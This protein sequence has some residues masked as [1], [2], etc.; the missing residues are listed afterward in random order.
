MTKVEAQLAALGNMPARELKPEWERLYKTAAPA[1]SADL[2]RLG[3][4]YRLQERAYGGLSPKLRRELERPGPGK[5]PLQLKA[6]T[7][8]L[9]SWNGRT[10]SVL[11]TDTGF[12]FEERQYRS[13][14]SIARKVTG[15]A[16]SGP[17]F[18]GLKNG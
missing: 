9:R 4:A 5:S 2:L 3:I 11:V 14:S 18:F 10:V 17:R 7:R 1:I 6:G 15:T 12:E 8:L 13:L 16:R